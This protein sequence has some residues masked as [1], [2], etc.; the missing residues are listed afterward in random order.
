MKSWSIKVVELGMIRLLKNVYNRCI[1]NI[2][3]EDEKV[4]LKGKVEVSKYQT[5]A[6]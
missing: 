1:K 4:N 6:R 3:Q 2:I 5:M